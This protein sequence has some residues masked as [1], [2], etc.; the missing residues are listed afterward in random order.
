[1]FDLVVFTQYPKTYGPRRFETEA[2]SQSDTLLLPDAK[3]V[4]LREP[5][6]KNN[7]YDLRDK[8]LNYYV[9]KE[10]KVLNSESYLKWS[11]LDKITQ[12]I[13]TY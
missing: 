6:Y 8:I 1:M 4:I 3:A 2:Q 11:V 5:D 12:R 9:S 10:V 13:H 7:I